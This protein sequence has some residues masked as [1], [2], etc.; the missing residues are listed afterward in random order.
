MS[1]GDSKR[2]KDVIEENVPVFVKY[3]EGDHMEGDEPIIW[4]DIFIIMVNKVWN[5][6]TIK[7][8]YFSIAN[9]G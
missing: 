2:A 7:F 6:Q 8:P 4:N 3:G 5:C 1:L 9:V